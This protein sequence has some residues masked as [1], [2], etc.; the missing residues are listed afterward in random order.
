MLLILMLIQPK[1]TKL[2]EG[3]PKVNYG[4]PWS[5]IAKQKSSKVNK[6]QPW[7]VKLKVNQSQLH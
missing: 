6:I 2:N 3:Q 7:L 4:L 1:S 5:T